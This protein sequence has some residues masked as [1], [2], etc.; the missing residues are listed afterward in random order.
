MTRRFKAAGGEID[1]V[2]MDGDTLVFV[3]VKFRARGAPEA[4][5]GHTKASRL[6]DAVDAY[7]TKTGT[8]A[9]PTRFDIVAV[10]PEGIRHHVGA[11]GAPRRRD[12]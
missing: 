6:S 8:H 1:I 7:L 12:G 4:A 9:A 11:F 5:V 2:A 10:T 3:E